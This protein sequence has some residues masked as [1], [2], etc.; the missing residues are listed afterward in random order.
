MHSPFG[1]PQMKTD[2]SRTRRYAGMDFTQ[3]RLPLPGCQPGDRGGGIHSEIP[4][5]TLL[6][7]LVGVHPLERG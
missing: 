6:A 3:H 1:H 7:G 2:T 5:D 4:F